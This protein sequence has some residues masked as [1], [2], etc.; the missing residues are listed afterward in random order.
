MK[1]VQDEADLRRV[2]DR[3]GRLVCVAFN[4][5]LAAKIVA[6]HLEFGESLMNPVQQL[7]AA[8][9]RRAEEIRDGAGYEIQE[10]ADAKD[11]AR[12]LARLISGES[13]RA[14]FGA[15]GDW[16]YS[17]AIG[18][19]LGRLYEAVPQDILAEPLSLRRE[20]EKYVAE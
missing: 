11:L 6:D 19:A 10:W 7:V 15:P 1:W 18:Q 13:V 8:I 2:V 3:S 20:Y 14:A 16:G 9:N 4:D 12:A 5:R 17:T